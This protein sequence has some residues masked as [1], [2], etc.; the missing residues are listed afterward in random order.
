M[1][2]CFN[3]IA[4]LL[5]SQIRYIAI[6]YRVEICVALPVCLIVSLFILLSC[7]SDLPSGI[8]FLLFKVHSLKVPLM[9]ICGRQNSKMPPRFIPSVYTFCV[10]F[11]P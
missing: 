11:S 9:R 7:V 4:V 8:I 10:I 5:I 6:I 3:Y 2:L 1:L